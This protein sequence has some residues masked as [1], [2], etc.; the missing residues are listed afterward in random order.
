MIEN[1]NLT[2][3]LKKKK[4]NPHSTLSGTRT[5]KV[6]TLD[7]A[8]GPSNPCTMPSNPFSWDILPKAFLTGP[9]EQRSAPG[10]GPHP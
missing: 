7:Q 6:L 2:A 9:Q 10:C 3:R 1:T 4:E 8:T 5:C